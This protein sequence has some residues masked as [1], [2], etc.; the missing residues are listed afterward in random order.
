M[1]D[2][3]NQGPGPNS[4]D[5]GGHKANHDVNAQKYHKEGVPGFWRQVTDLLIL[6]GIIAVLIF[7]FSWIF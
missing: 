2:F 7:I 5:P 1:S 6:V 3:F 4:T